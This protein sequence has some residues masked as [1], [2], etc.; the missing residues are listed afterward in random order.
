MYIKKLW[1]NEELNKCIKIRDKLVNQVQKLISPD[2]L[3][4][5]SNGFGARI[6]DVLSQ[7]AI[8][9]KKCKKGK[10]KGYGK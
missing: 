3:T 2:V 1:V 5:F 8:M 4:I 7:E 6:I 10:K 9:A